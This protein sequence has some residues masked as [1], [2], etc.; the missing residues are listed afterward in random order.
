M[1]L[2]G[3]I[4]WVMTVS[5]SIIVNVRDAAATSVVVLSELI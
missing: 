1:T 4:D 5:S 2:I 3:Q